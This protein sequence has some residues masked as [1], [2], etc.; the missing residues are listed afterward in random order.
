MEV[1][2]MRPHRG[3]WCRETFNDV[4]AAKVTMVEDVGMAQGDSVSRECHEL[5]RFDFRYDQRA[6]I[7]TDAPQAVPRS[8]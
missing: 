4:K 3:I 2:G 8:W 1:F 5:L 7:L 6:L